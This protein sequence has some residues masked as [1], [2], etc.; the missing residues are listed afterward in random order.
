MPTGSYRTDDVEPRCLR[1][2]APIVD[3]AWYPSATVNDLATFCF[4]ASVRECPVKLLDASD[5]RVSPDISPSEAE[6]AEHTCL[7]VIAQGILFDRRS[8]GTTNC[9]SLSII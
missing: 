5:G 9:P 3:Y 1:Q 2:P 8:Q 6:R 7:L 4:L